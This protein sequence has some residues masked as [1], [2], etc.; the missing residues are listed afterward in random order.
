MCGASNDAPY[1]LLTGFDTTK[2]KEA[3]VKDEV[4]TQS[5][6]TQVKPMFSRQDL[7][8]ALNNIMNDNAGN[9]NPNVNY[10]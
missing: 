4:S 9:L 3:G 6:T 5:N 7:G 1:R 10:I 2:K 8:A